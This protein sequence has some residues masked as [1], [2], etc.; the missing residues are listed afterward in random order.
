M[1]DRHTGERD[2]AVSQGFVRGNHL[3][4]VEFTA[5]RDLGTVLGVLDEDL[6][7]MSTGSVSRDR[8]S[9]DKWRIQ[10]SQVRVSVV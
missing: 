2:Q 1:N 6:N 8:N 10:G 5:S 9:R 7:E 4:I 3:R